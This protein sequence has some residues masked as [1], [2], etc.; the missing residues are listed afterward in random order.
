MRIW[1]LSP[2]RL[3]RSHLLGEHR[4]LH[5]IWS[6]LTNNRKGYSGHP[7][8]LRWKGKLKALFLRHEDLVSE[9]L[10][11]G[12]RHESPLDSALARGASVQTV[13]VDFPEDQIL[14]LRSK[15]CECDI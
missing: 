6:I 15:R 3:C 7:E 5:A 11:R 1:D 14:R 2:E 9:M 13:Y 4:E 10:R 12:Y 8:V